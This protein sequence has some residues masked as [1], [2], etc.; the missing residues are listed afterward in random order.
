M[1]N[2]LN[3]EEIEINQDLLEKTNP[4]FNTAL[5]TLYQLAAAGYDDA[6]D[7]AERLNLTQEDTQNSK[8]VKGDD[9]DLFVNSVI[10]DVR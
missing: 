8:T 6:R 2:M 5:M 1:K 7:V 10:M 9:Y 4:I 3:F